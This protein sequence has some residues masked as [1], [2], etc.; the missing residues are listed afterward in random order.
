MIMKKNIPE[1]QIP[2]YQCPGKP[3]LVMEAPGSAKAV[4]SSVRKGSKVFLVLASLAP[5]SPSNNLI[6]G[7]EP[8]SVLPLCPVLLP[9]DPPTRMS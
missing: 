2:A 8:S 3:V 1:N 6:L 4:N 7:F 5:G 9:S